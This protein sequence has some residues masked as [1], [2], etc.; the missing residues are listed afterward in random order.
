MNTYEN[1][2]LSLLS[3]KGFAMVARHAKNIFLKIFP[4]MRSETEKTHVTHLLVLK[5]YRKHKFAFVFRDEKVDLKN[6][7][8]ICTDINLFRTKYSQLVS[9]LLTEKVG[10]LNLLI[11]KCQSQRLRPFWNNNCLSV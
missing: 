11:K 7:E 9:F 3:P 6:K 4:C 10:D 5:F 2:L 1:H 8:E